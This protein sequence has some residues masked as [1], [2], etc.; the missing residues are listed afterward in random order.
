MLSWLPKNTPQ[1][2]AIVV[3]TIDTH[4]SCENLI[5]S[6]LEVIPVTKLT[7][8]EIRQGAGT[9]LARYDKKLSEEQLQMILDDADDTG[10]PLYLRLTLDEVR[11]FGVYEKLNEEMRILL[12]TNGVIELYNLIITR[13]ETKFNKDGVL[14]VE[15]AM[16]VL[17]VSRIGLSEGDLDNYVKDVVGI[18]FSLA[19][20]K[21]FFF[22][23]L[24]SLF[25]RNGRYM[26]FHQLLVETTKMRFFGESNTLKETQ[27]HYGTW[28]LGQYADITD[29]DEDTVAEICHQLLSGECYDALVEYLKKEFVVESML[30]GR[31]RYEFFNCWRSIHAK[32]AANYK[33]I[34]SNIIKSTSRAGDALVEFFVEAYESSYLIANIPLRIAKRTGEVSKVVDYL[35]LGRVHK[36]MK[37]WTDSLSYF[38]RCL[39]VKLH[40]TSSDESLALLYDEMG[41]VYLQQN[42]FVDAVSNFEKALSIRKSLFGEVDLRV[43][44]SHDQ[45]GH[46]YMS[47]NKFEEAQKSFNDALEIRAKLVGKDHP[48]MA[49]SLVNSAYVDK[50][51]QRFEYSL[52]KLGKA[53]AIWQVT[54]GRAHPS[55]ALAQYQIAL[56]YEMQLKF[57]ECLEEL[58]KARDILVQTL[59]ENHPDTVEIYE[60]IGDAEHEVQNYTKS[61][62]AYNSSLS[63]RKRTMGENHPSVAAAYENVG[64]TNFELGRRD[65]VGEFV[66]SALKIRRQTGTKTLIPTHQTGRIADLMREQKAVFDAQQLYK[67]LADRFFKNQSDH[68]WS[69]WALLQKI[70]RLLFESKKHKEGLQFWK[71]MTRYFSDKLG[72]T[73]DRTLVSCYSAFTH[74]Y[75]LDN[76]TSLLKMTDIADFMRKN[77]NADWSNSDLDR[78]KVAG[79]LLSIVYSSRKDKD[80]AS[81]AGQAISYL[82]FAGYSLSGLDLSGV[83][84]EKANLCRAVLDGTSFKGADLNGSRFNE[85]FLGDCVFDEANMK[86]VYFGPGSNQLLM[87]NDGALCA[88]ALRMSEECVYVAYGGSDKIIH[89]RD[90]STGKELFTLEGHRSCITSLC[91]LVY[92]DEIPWIVSGSKDGHV[93]IWDIS[94]RDRIHSLSV[95]KEP[96]CSLCVVRKDKE[97]HMVVS[98]SEDGLVFIWNVESDPEY[99]LQATHAEGNVKLCLFNGLDQKLYLATGDQQG[100]IQI[101][102]PYANTFVYDLTP[103]TESSSGGVRSICSA[104][105]PNKAIL[106]VVGHADGVLSVWNFQHGRKMMRLKGHIRSVEDVCSISGPHG[107]CWLASGSEDGS[108]SIWDLESGLCVRTLKGHK[109]SVFNV[110]VINQNSHGVLLGSASQ[111][112]VIKLWDLE[113]DVMIKANLGEMARVDS[114][115]SVKGP[116]GELWLASGGE[117]KIVRVWEPLTG[118]QVKTITGIVGCIKCMCTAYGPKKENWLIIGG[119]D[120]RIIVWDLDNW[121][122]VRRIKCSTPEVHSVRSLQRENLASEK[123][124]LASAGSD[125]AVRIWDLSTG[126]EEFQLDGHTGDVMSL[127]S[128][129]LEDGRFCILSASQDKTIKIWDVGSRT[130][131]RTL[132]GHTGAVRS[133]ICHEIPKQRALVASGGDDKTVRIWDLSSGTTLSILDGYTGSIA[134]VCMI[135]GV[136]EDLWF[137]AGCQDGQV[138]AKNMRSEWKACFSRRQTG[139]VC[140]ICRLEG[141]EGKHLFATSSADQKIYIW[142]LAEFSSQE[143][144][145]SSIMSAIVGDRAKDVFQGFAHRDEQIKKLQEESGV[146][147]LVVRNILGHRTLE[148]GRISFQKVDDLSQYDKNILLSKGG[149]SYDADF[150]SYCES[151][152]YTEDQAQCMVKCYENGWGVE[153]DERKASEW[154]F[155]SNQVVSVTSEN[156]REGLRVRRGRDWK[157]G[158][159]DGGVGCLGTLVRPDSTG[160]WRVKWD[161][162]G[163]ANNYRTGADGKYDLEYASGSVSQE[164]DASFNAGDQVELAAGYESVSDAKDGPLSQGEVGEVVRVDTSDDTVQV[165]S[166]DGRTWW[167]GFRAIK[168]TSKEPS[169]SKSVS[170]VI[171]VGGYVKLSDDYKQCD[172]A[173]G[174]PLQP[175]DV[176][177]VLQDDKSS[178]PYQVKSSTGKTWWYTKDALVAVS[179]KPSWIN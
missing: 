167:Y 117:D 95:H 68:S 47:E 69:G 84:L 32:G 87:E 104:I 135:Q 163:N 2:L 41:G 79:A 165:K 154:S 138:C 143:T 118:M 30:G 111:D 3:S 37:N 9:Y 12:S 55:V 151:G 113:S 76:Q 106:L 122:E 174:G 116:R 129:V 19:L 153:K 160:W 58:Y 11:V 146:C 85:A 126:N 108:V 132:V 171:S 66:S 51:F 120:K 71:D 83:K 175:G 4:I 96:I 89:V 23:L 40:T 158:D 5:K 63:V 114:L 149:I 82:N 176:G 159:Q 54:L 98:A 64:R 130:L 25:V 152:D 44:L 59:G 128:V 150:V 136:N 90:P 18:K 112:Q 52:E 35:A 78:D 93:F 94:K 119:T 109:Q 86:D 147:G 172:D 121:K 156:A 110:F 14:L 99:E 70:N 38:H 125:N 123:I 56:I 161:K 157:W 6:G 15:T 26:Y 28:L 46:C 42:R 50:A 48:L 61:L 34:Y 124:L 43:A 107:E 137:V 177:V 92:Q 166:T 21:S 173:S 100:R 142:D 169:A 88:A 7:L 72:P 29:S 27:K 8:D 105:G 1:N 31:Y 141:Q 145:E 16:K 67:E 33:E 101:F 75:E 20:W 49:T 45:F 102:D 140:G 178:K 162:T 164:S 103:A 39:E 74:Q 170:T 57:S 155:K 115:C 17:Y 10:H 148:G 179:E 77:H 13:W 168:K 22:T 91:S 134:S 60:K 139:S 73:N 62:Q 97:Q 144:G 53:M 65:Q 24:D 131:I 81:T 127:C 36:S 133:V 80:K